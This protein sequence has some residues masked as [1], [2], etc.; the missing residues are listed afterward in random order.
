MLPKTVRVIVFADSRGTLTACA[1]YQL[2]TLG[3]QITSK[4]FRPLFHFRAP[5][6]RLGHGWGACYQESARWA[7]RAYGL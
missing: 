5:L 7:I 3:Q 1:S 4:G 2:S 6:R